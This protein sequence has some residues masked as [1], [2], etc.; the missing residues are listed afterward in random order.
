MFTYVILNI[1]VLAVICVVLARLHAFVFSR[2]I[3][4]LGI[5]L[6]TLTIVFDSFIII[7]DIVHYDQ[8]KLLGLTLWAA[9]IEDLMY[10]VLAIMIVPAIWE[11]LGDSHVQ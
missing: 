11:K 2:T 1:V 4:W 7:A 3:L 5:I 9:P 8:T 6:I 10:T